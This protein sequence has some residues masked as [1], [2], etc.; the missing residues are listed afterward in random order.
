MAVRMWWCPVWTM[1]G[2]ICWCCGQTLPNRETRLQI[3]ATRGRDRAHRQAHVEI[4]S[5]RHRTQILVTTGR[6]SVCTVRLARRIPC[7][8]A[9]CQMGESKPARWCACE[10]AA[11]RRVTVPT[12]RVSAAAVKV[13][14][15]GFGHRGSTYRLAESSG[16][17]PPVGAAE[18]SWWRAPG[19]VSSRLAGERS[20]LTILAGGPAR[21]LECSWRRY[22]CTALSEAHTNHFLENAP[23]EVVGSQAWHPCRAILRRTELGLTPGETRP[24]A[25]SSRQLGS[26]ASAADAVW[27]A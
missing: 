6:L 11:A 22:S 10:I 8:T 3:T 9:M 15:H 7:A 20:E 13:R 18:G 21:T 19:T 26:R 17:I 5:P 4:E 16:E 24:G 25:G 23:D 12:V 14:R 27:G 2:R 1:R